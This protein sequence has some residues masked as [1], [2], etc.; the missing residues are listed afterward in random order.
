MSALGLEDEDPSE[1]EQPYCDYCEK[2]GHYF[3]ECP[4]RDDESEEEAS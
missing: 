2:E 4:A 1:V 3:R